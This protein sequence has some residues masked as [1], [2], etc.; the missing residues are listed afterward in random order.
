MK[1]LTE[2]FLIIIIPI[3]VNKFYSS[4]LVLLE[5]I[6]EYVFPFEPDLSNDRHIKL[7]KLG[8]NA[9][10]EGAYSRMLLT[11]P[12]TVNLRYVENVSLFLKAVKSA[13]SFITS[14]V[15][16]ILNILSDKLKAIPLLYFRF[17]QEE[18]GLDPSFFHS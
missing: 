6:N 10:D 4:P 13:S 1:F 18:L 7:N 9:F 16:I 12:I 15:T 11:T 3:I 5:K 8:V 14:I 2:I 17:P